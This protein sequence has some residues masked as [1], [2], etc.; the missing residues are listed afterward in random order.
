MRCCLLDKYFPEDIVWISVAIQAET[1][2]VATDLVLKF[3][4]SLKSLHQLLP[5]QIKGEGPT[6]NCEIARN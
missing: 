3:I 6:M 4:Q 1:N 2:D 5:G